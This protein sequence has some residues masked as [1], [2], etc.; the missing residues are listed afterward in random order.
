MAPFRKEPRILV[1]TPELSFLPGSM[2]F[3]SQEMSARAGGLGDAAAT[4]VQALY[5]MGADVH[6]AIPNYRKIFRGN[7][8][9]V[10]GDEFSRWSCEMP[11]ENIHLVQ[12]RSFF[13]LPK[14]FVDKG[15]DN[16]KIALAFQRE[17][18][19]RVVPI[20]QPDLIHCC[21][22]MTGLIP[23]MARKFG[24]PC[25]FTLYNVD[26]VRLLLATIEENGIDAAA[27]WEKCYYTRMP[28]NYEETRDTNPVDFL[29]SAVFSAHFVNTLS[30]AFSKQIADGACDFIDPVLKT[31]LQNKIRAG[32]HVA[33]EHA[34]PEHFDPLTDNALCRRYKAQD[35]PAAKALNK[36]H[37][38]EVLG[39]RVDDK[40]ALFF[41]PTRLDRSR[42]GCRLLADI[43]PRLLSR[44]ARQDLQV[45]CIADGDLHDHFRAM[46]EQLKAGDRV[47]IRDFDPTHYRLAFAAADF[48]LMP[49]QHEPCGLPC[50][51]GQRYGALPIGHDTGGIHDALDPLDVANNRGNGFVFCHCDAHGLAWAIDQAMAFFRLPDAVR[52]R[53]IGR[54]MTESWLRY[55][56]QKTALTYIDLYERMLQRPF[57]GWRHSTLHSVASTLKAAA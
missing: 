3:P 15:W 30:P 54:I 25:L 56:G 20:V 10:P 38:Q 29:V 5:K 33:I 18:I 24:I 22:W 11:H 4:L 36:L 39:L 50:K 9:A 19:N 31:E 32:C 45:V 27:F 8:G 40:A 21:G 46:V 42:R 47:A 34:P 41:W 49:M 12:D 43:L 51:L 37:L 26:T 55:D 13:H 48:V 23:A 28:A 57:D 7:A 14:L 6:V 1:A 17:V 2:G 44:Y 53:Q 16:I 35:H 52:A